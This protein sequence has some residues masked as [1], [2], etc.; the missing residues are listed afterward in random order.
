MTVMT[1]SG[2]GIARVSEAPFDSH[3]R[4]RQIAFRTMYDEWERL[5]EITGLMRIKQTEYY[6]GT[7]SHLKIYEEHPDVSSGVIKMP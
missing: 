4:R 7:S 3:G 5:G 6:V 1:G 2:D